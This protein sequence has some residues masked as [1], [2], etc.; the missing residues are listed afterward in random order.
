MGNQ[1][2]F[3]RGVDQL[4][5]IAHGMVNRQV[6]QLLINHQAEQQAERHNNQAAQQQ[7][8]SIDSAEENS[9]RKIGKAQIRFSG[10]FRIRPL[11]EKSRQMKK[12]GRCTKSGKATVEP[13]NGRHKNPC[14]ELSHQNLNFIATKTWSQRTLVSLRGGEATGLYHH[15]FSVVVSY[16]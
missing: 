6:L 7:G 2:R 8:A 4:R 1:I 11:R 3:A 10:S 14:R 13:L 5:N 9:L 12:T 16:L 15:Q